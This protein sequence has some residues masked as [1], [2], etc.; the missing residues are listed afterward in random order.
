MIFLDIPC[1]PCIIGIFTKGSVEMAKQE[2]ITVQVEED[3]K[4]RFEAKAKSEERT[5]SA[6]IR[7]LM[8]QYLGE[9]E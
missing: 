9:N 8:K 2:Y 4:E 3:L 5:V 1:Y 6:A 7:H